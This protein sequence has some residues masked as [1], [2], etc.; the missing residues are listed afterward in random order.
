VRV[1]RDVPESTVALA[2]QRAGGIARGLPDAAE[3]KRVR[4]LPSGSRGMARVL[5]TDGE[6]RAALATVRA[7]GRAGH[8]VYVTAS[9]PRSL[10]AVSRFATDGA[11]VARAATHP[12][13]AVERLSELA[14]EW[15]V[16]V[17]LPVTDATMSAVL[18]GPR[19][20]FGRA[21]VAGPDRD[22]YE[23]V[24]DKGTV[25][26]RAAALGCPVPRTAVVSSPGE[27][28]A[29]A[30]EVGFPCVLKP[31]RSVGVGGRATADF[32]PRYVQ[33]P[34]ALGA[35]AAGAPYPLLVQER[36]V[37]TGEGVFVLMDRGRRVAAF[38]HRR[39]REKPPSGG[40]STYR[41]SVP[42]APDTLALAERL[43][44]DVAWHGVAMVEFKRC[45][46]T[47]RA[48]LMEVNGRLWGSLQLAIDAGVNFPELLV[49]LA[50]GQPVG[51]GAEYRAGVRS[52]WLWGDVD[53]LIA[54][55]R[56]SRTELHLEPDAPSVLGT[57]WAFVQFWR[58][59]DRLEVWDADDPRP[60]W[61]ET[62]AWF[63]GRS[64]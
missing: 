31:P 51:A 63:Q 20:R 3:L 22:A 7:L 62:L 39:L 10:A 27:L 36:I 57:I 13:E 40:A 11:V 52:R 42:L 6:T 28:E 43:L 37:G 46:R 33:D 26:A 60:F 25:L 64:A 23:A 48:Y 53:H 35:A 18:R 19:S 55:V 30:R 61:S 16:D 54:R 5:V 49:R 47:G 56:R 17:V 45:A 9:H 34:A 29:A 12:R 58:R 41:E 38:A 21:V 44:A 59:A 4:G 1:L 32:G 15:D 8:A 24:S 14:A 2:P 50:L